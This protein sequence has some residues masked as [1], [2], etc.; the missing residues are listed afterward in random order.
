MRRCRALRAR[1]RTDHGASA[2][3]FGLVA[4]PLMLLLIG[5]IQFSIWLWAY[6]VGAHAAREGARVAAVDP[7]NGAAIET[8]VIDRVGSAADSGLVVNPEA[9]PFVVGD[10]VT[11]N[12]SYVPFKIGFF[13]MPNISKSAT[14]RVEYVPVGSC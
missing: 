9:G 8:R 12:V 14:A 6:Q 11:V 5:I 13:P 1:K 4:V 10:S 2:V 3:E 7:C